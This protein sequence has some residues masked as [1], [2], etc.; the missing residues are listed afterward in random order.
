MDG[1][2]IGGGQR[3]APNS[4]TATLHIAHRLPRERSSPSPLQTE[5][6]CERYFFEPDHLGK[7]STGA[8]A[9]SLDS[10]HPSALV[11]R[12]SF[13]RGG[14]RWEHKAIRNGSFGAGYAQTCLE[15]CMEGTLYSLQCRLVRI[16]VGQHGNG[17]QTLVG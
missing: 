2:C 8:I 15:V 5:D 3:G 7:T 1:Q 14:F 11:S 4:G 13:R 17:H 16:L 9:A 12:S 10:C 6:P